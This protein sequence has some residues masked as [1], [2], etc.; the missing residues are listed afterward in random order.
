[1]EKAKERR[2]NEKKTNQVDPF[3]FSGFLFF[4]TGRVPFCRFS[5]SSRS[6][7]GTAFFRYYDCDCDDYI[8]CLFCFYGRVCRH[9]YR[10]E[11]EGVF[12]MLDPCIFCHDADQFP[13]VYVFLL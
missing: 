4:D 9:L 8:N 10:Q 2:L 5:S 1:M 6:L 11:E 13:S 7:F 3:C 12:S